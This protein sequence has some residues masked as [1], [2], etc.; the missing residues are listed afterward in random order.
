MK[1]LSNTSG[2]AVPVD[3]QKLAETRSLAECCRLF[4]QTNQWRTLSVMA[5]SIGR[6]VRGYIEKLGPRPFVG[7]RAILQ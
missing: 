7:Q 4:L 5:G 1:R 6:T 2:A 3:D